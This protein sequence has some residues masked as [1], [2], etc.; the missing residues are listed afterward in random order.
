MYFCVFTCPYVCVHVGLCIYMYMCVFVCMHACR[1][2]CLC[3]HIREKVS[4]QENFI[5]TL[6]YLK[7][8]VYVCECCI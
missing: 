1:H 3:V 2:V 5:K 4:K 8:Q 7:Q 6:Q